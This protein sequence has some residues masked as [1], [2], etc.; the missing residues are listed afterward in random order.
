MAKRLRSG[1]SAAAAADRIA[2]VVVIGA[3]SG[4]LEALQELVGRLLKGVPAAF[5]V[6]QHLAP[7]QPSQLVDLLRR[8]ARLPVE[9]AVD[10]ALLEPGLILVI[11]PGCNASLEG[12]TLRLTPPQRCYG[13]S[14]SI[15]QL[16]DSLA[17]QWGDRG[18]AAVLSGTGSD[19]ACGLRAV[20]AAGGLTLVQSPESARFTSMPLAAIAMGGA[21]LIA[22]PA[23]LGSHLQRLHCRPESP[24]AAGV[25]EMDG[26]MLPNAVAQ[27]K[28]RTGIDFSLYKESTLR[29]Q[30]QR[31]LAILGLA[32]MEDY[33]AL[34]R[35]D[36]GECQT[37]MQ[38]LLVTVTSF[39]RNPDAFSALV[40]ALKPL[41]AARDADEPFRVWVPGCATGEEV[42]SIG[43]ALSEAMGHPHQLT[44]ELKIFATDLDERSLRIARRGVYPL[45]A[46]R[47]IPE[48]LQQRYIHSKGHEF[49]I[50]KELRSCI[51]FARHNICDDPPFPNIDLVSC[52][53]L[54]IYFTA[55]L[56]AQVIDLLGIALRPGGLLLLGSSESLSPAAGFRLLNPVQRLYERTVEPRPRRRTARAMQTRRPSTP[57][58]PSVDPAHGPSPVPAQHIQL[59]EVLVRRFVR[60]SL[61][62]DENHHLLEVIGD[63][64]PYCRIPAGRITADASTFLREE[65]QS[66]ARALFLLVRADRSAVRSCSLRLPGVSSPVWLEAAPLRVADQ[67][68]TILSFHQDPDADASPVA[69]L[70]SADR[71]VAFAREIERL[72]RELLS[73]QDTLRRSMV[74]LEQANQELEASSEELQASAEELQSSNEELEASNEELQATNDE[75]AALNQQ[76]RAR[77]DELERLNT[78]MENIQ[79]SLSQ[80]MVIVDQELRISRYSPLAVRVF[81]L[82]PSDLGQPLIGIPTTVPIPG[83]RDS[84]LEVIGSQARLSLEASGDDVS[85]LV[86]LMPYRNGAGLVLGAILTLTDV[87]ELV[88][89]RV[90]AEASLQEF[91][92][93]ADALEQVVWKRDHTSK[94]FLYL[95]RRVEP[96]TGWSALELI[97]DARLFDDAI[98]PHD[99]AGVEAARQAGLDGWAVTYRLR[100]RD[101]E[102]RVVNEV[103]TVLDQGHPDG[104]V[105]E[106]VGT[107]TDVTDQ[108]RVR[109]RGRLFR[110]A[111]EAISAEGVALVALLDRSLTL[112]TV[113]ERLALLLGRAR[114]DLE[115]QP[116]DVLAAHLCFAEGNDAP[117]SLREGAQVALAGGGEPLHG[118]VRLQPAG[119]AHQ[120][121]LRPLRDGQATLGLLLS[122]RPGAEA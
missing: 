83:L 33:L 37:L 76:L 102:E 27:L 74:D 5:V 71:D 64:S 92:S 118:L 66:E 54:L 104:V 9:A 115:G 49:E 10:G 79:T 96:L 75:L 106:V 119:A 70:T 114:A 24:A 107:L 42:Y 38:N 109:L 77:G 82:V 4:G 53:N 6:A 85:Y 30:I 19:G 43:M 3:S 100:R 68:L 84:L 95:N 22:D 81:G 110:C 57:E 46:A 88:A 78:D 34:L 117:A 121:V 58:R 87:S 48:G 108:E 69:G 11:P 97:A 112:V 56:Q 122:L 52:R 35:S 40:P 23:A 28:K 14:P 8:G 7:D 17:V 26:L 16:L 101:G 13:P 36:A 32:G 90:A 62:L 31:R 60:P 45:S 98:H 67:A 29:R 51:V 113:A 61:V 18:V 21:D 111:F 103:A 1:T 20:G 93:L 89:L 73:S 39:F 86:Q 41:L 91:A 59:L 116:L 12:E 105:G 55:D 25:A 15:D 120:L 65:L 44:R 50:S 94:R 63:V 47:A 72:E 80:G 2:R 99:R